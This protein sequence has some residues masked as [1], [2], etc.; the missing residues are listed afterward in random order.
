MDVAP[1]GTVVV[2]SA[3][4]AWI[5][6]G[7][8]PSRGDAA[9]SS[10]R[11]RGISG[12]GAA[13]DVQARGRAGTADAVGRYAPE[14]AAGTAGAIGAS[15]AVEVAGAMV[16][17]KHARAIRGFRLPSSCVTEARFSEDGERC[18]FGTMTGEIHVV[19]R[20]RV[21]SLIFLEEVAV[22]VFPVYVLAAM[23]PSARRGR[24]TVHV[25][26]CPA[27]VIL[28]LLIAFS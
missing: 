28:S 7:E 1:S 27:V 26:L 9:G 17:M 4:F 5:F 11:S 25:L 3:D 23:M 20:V 22:A 8:C 24:H 18:F 10:S 6:S 13:A 12:D 2:C 16:A 19:S 14:A 15:G 21:F